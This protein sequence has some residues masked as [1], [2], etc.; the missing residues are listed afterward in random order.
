MKPLEISGTADGF[1]SD[2]DE[3]YLVTDKFGQAEELGVRQ[4]DLPKSEEIECPDEFE[5]SN[6]DRC[7]DAGQ[8]SS[9]SLS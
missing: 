4:C 8:L 7:C 5:S 1:A 6:S 9:G 2:S 3:V